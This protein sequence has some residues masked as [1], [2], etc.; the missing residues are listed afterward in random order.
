M[1]V[2]HPNPDRRDSRAPV[3]VEDVLA[4]AD[5]ILHSEGLKGSGPLRSLLQYLAKRAAESSAPVK[6]HDIAIDVF[7]RGSDFDSRLDSVVRVHSARLRSKLAEYYMSEGMQDELVLE[8]PKGAY[9]LVGHRRSVPPASQAARPSWRWLRPALLVGVVMFALAAGG[10]LVYRAT[11]G[12][13]ALRTFWREFLDNRE[14]VIVVFSNPRF[15]GSSRTGLRQFQEGADAPAAANDTYTGT[16][17]VMAVHELTKAL[18]TFGK[19]MRVKRSQLLT[20]DEARGHDLIFIG[21]PVHNFPVAQ[22]RLQQFS[23]KQSEGMTTVVNEK[24]RPG[25]QPDY[26]C[27]PSPPFKADYAVIARLPGSDRARN[28][29]VLAGTTTYGTQAAAEFVSREDSVAELLAKLGVVRGG[30]VPHFDALIQVRVTGG[31]AIEPRLLLVH[32]EQT[33]P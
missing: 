23:F 17:E 10:F 5:R 14:D 13:S 4:E 11:T 33:G 9:S 6:E 1:P 21:A 8:I 26:Y 2:V 29:L 15:A 3:S 25:E 24:P 7:N 28:A 18:L 12:R 30:A 20:W 19:P 27:E 16:G 31:V 22:I 32:G